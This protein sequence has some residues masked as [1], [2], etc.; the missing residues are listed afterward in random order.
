MKSL[1]CFV[2]IAMAADVCESVKFAAYFCGVLG[3][4]CSRWLEFKLNIFFKGTENIENKFVL[5]TMLIF[6]KVVPNLL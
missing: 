5:G 4:Y 2:F 3:G 1:L 6:R